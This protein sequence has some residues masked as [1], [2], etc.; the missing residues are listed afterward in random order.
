MAE[1]LNLPFATAYITTAQVDH[2]VRCTSCRLQLF[3]YG[4]GI[5]CVVQS[6]A[7]GVMSPLQML[8]AAATDIH[9][10]L[11]LAT[12]LRFV[13]VSISVWKRNLRIS[14]DVNADI[15]FLL[16]NLP[17]SIPLQY[18]EERKLMI[19][20]INNDGLQMTKAMMACFGE[21]QFWAHHAAWARDQVARG[22]TGANTVGTTARGK[23][24]A[25]ACTT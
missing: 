4:S 16:C 5:S 13:N 1:G 18:C 23:C 15:T 7:S 11:C 21:K 22:L 20:N 19:L 9:G 14:P 25:A 12:P 3:E 10:L 6:Y 24:L 17:C 8:L 2:C